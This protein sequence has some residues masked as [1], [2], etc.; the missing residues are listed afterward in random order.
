[1]GFH[2]LAYLSPVDLN[3]GNLVEGEGENVL[4]ILDQGL[5]TKRFP[6]TLTK[7]CTININTHTVVTLTN[8][9][10]SPSRHLWAGSR[11]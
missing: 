11:S 10:H 2:K 4:V 1:M 5:I 7:R 9:S 3:H 8:H 6:Q